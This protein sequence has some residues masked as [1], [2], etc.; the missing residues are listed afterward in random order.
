MFS[1]FY[2]NTNPQILPALDLRRIMAIYYYLGKSRLF[3]FI[4]MILNFFWR[5]NL[6]FGGGNGKCT[7]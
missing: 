5:E 7:D 1:R 3:S 2:V 6:Y 4:Q